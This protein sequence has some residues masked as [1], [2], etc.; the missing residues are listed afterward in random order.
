MQKIIKTHRQV[1]IQMEKWLT[2]YL[3]KPKAAFDGCEPFTF[4]DSLFYEKQNRL[5]K[6]MDLPPDEIPVFFLPV[7]EDEYII[8]T[9]RR[10]L[11]L[12]SDDHESLLFTDFAGH[13]GFKFASRG[14]KGGSVAFFILKRKT[15]RPLFWEIPT[16][17]PGH[18]FWTVTNKCELI[19][20]RYDVTNDFYLDR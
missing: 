10:F 5:Y 2:R 12:S 14:Y 9:T 13:Q 3:D 15:E 8:T 18:A 20:R 6:L 16:G 4:F 11:R 17:Q 19:G 7:R 1:S